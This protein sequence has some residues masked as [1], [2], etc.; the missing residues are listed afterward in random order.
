MP[1]GRRPGFSRDPEAH[2]S[3]ED[4]ARLELPRAVPPVPRGLRARE[5]A[6]YTWLAAQLAR[7]GVL[8]EVDA[9]ILEVA[10]IELELIR[11]AWREI[12]RDGLVVR[13]AKGAARRH[14]A[15]A[16]LERAIK[17]YRA[18]CSHLGLSPAERH[19]VRIPAGA[20]AEDDEVEEIFRA[21]RH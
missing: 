17:S 6:T 10:A 19:R 3:L 14:P 16:T 21:T 7:A 11:R 9:G 12:R 20:A 18:T 15:L 4:R 5:R 1:R 2:R 8:A 13:D